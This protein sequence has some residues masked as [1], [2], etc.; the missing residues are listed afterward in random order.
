MRLELFEKSENKGPTIFIKS[1]KIVE[2]SGIFNFMK[3]F[4]SQKFQIKI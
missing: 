2:T 3:N 4:I 1:M